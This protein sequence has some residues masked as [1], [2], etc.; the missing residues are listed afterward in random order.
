MIP[1]ISI[2]ASSIF[3]HEPLTYSLLAGL[4]LIVT[5]ICLV[6]S[7]SKAQKAAAICVNKKAAQ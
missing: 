1:L 6:N 5:S 7:K 2:V 4:L 3:L